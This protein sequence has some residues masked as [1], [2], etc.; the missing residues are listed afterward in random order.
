MVLDAGV[1]QLDVYTDSQ[2]VA[3]QIE[4]SHEMREWSMIRYLRK[5]KHLMSKFDKCIIQQV[6]REENTRT[7][8][9]S[10]FGAMVTGVKGRKIAVVVKEKAL[11]EEGEVIQCVEGE[12]SWK[13][14]IEEYLI[15][16]SELKDPI[17]A[18]R[19]KFRANKFTMINGELYRRTAEG[20]LL[21]CLG[22]EKTK[23]VVRE[24]QEGSCENH[25]RGRSLALKVTRQGYL[26]NFGKG[27][28]GVHEAAENT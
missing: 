28:Y 20:P 2:L 16:G 9:L 24:I 6:P 25:S 8:A 19:L 13:K 1:K 21:K 4:G 3:M 27:C 23:Y 26:A 17:L 10:K 11:I 18:K 22:V 5:V 15:Q 12:K 14:E 7:D